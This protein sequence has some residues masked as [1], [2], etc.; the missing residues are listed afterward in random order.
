MSTPFSLLDLRWLQDSRV[1]LAR[2]L[3]QKC[4]WRDLE[5]Q[6]SNVRCHCCLGGCE[7]P[8]YWNG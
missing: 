1:E 3:D 6:D 2:R 5:G 8:G 4:D 7:N